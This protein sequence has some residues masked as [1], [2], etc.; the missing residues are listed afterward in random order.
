MEAP[1]VNRF[2]APTNLKRR[3]RGWTWRKYCFSRL[4]YAPTAIEPCL[5]QLR[6]RVFNRLCQF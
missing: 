4:R 1:R 6:W 2:L 3:S 5:Y